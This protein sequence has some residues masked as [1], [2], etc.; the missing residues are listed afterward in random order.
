MSRS[1]GPA[2]INGLQSDAL[3][4]L[5]SGETNIMHDMTRD[6][7]RTLIMAAL[8]AS[9]GRRVDAASRLGLG[10]NTITRKMRELGL[11]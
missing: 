8:H 10:R 3:D 4:R 9:G 7:E 1:S 5:R 6:F 11:E 2:W